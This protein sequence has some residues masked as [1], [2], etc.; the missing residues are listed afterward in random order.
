MREFAL[1]F[2]EEGKNTV[3][4]VCL[5][6]LR[7]GQWVE[8]T[9]WTFY[10]ENP[11]KWSGMLKCD[12]REEHSGDWGGKFVDLQTYTLRHTFFQ[13]FRKCQEKSLQLNVLNTVKTLLCQSL[14]LGHVR[15]DISHWFDCLRC[16]VKTF[17]H[18]IEE[19][20]WLRLIWYWSTIIVLNQTFISHMQTHQVNHKSA[21]NAETAFEFV[22]NNGQIFWHE[23]TI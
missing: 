14:H 13:V 3:I 15:T 5:Q 18:W 8:Q 2:K 1:P 21:W 16:K 19:D 9:K 23:G 12:G 10:K 20:C 22:E 11:L 6:T 17:N 7:L 4:Q